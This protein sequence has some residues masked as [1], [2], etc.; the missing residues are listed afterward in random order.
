[1][2]IRGAGNILGGEQHGHMEAVGYDLYLKLLADAVAE[3]KGEQPVSEVDCT[4]DL[5]IDAHIPENYISSLPQR[6]AIYRRI[7]E[8]RTDDDAADVLDELIDRF[9]EPPSSVRGLIEISLLRSRAASA[10]IYEVIKGRPYAL[11]VSKINT[12]GI[13]TAGQLRGRIMLIAATNPI[14]RLK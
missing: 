12:Q 10:S 6:L 7:A 3:E 8:I 9:G 14:F 11:Y 5:R 1:M 4:I 2:E 13:Q